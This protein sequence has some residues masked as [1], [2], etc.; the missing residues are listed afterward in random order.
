MLRM[1]VS[2]SSGSEKTSLVLS[3]LLNDCPIHK[4]KYIDWNH[5]ILVSKPLGQSE[6]STLVFAIRNNLNKEQIAQIYKDSDKIIDVKKVILNSKPYQYQD[7][8]WVDEY[9]KIN[10]NKLYVSVFNKPSELPELNTM[11]F[12]NREKP[13]ILIDDCL[14][15]NNK[16]TSEL[17]IFG[18]N[19]KLPII[20]LSQSYAR[21]QKGT[22]RDNSNMFIL[23]SQTIRNMRQMIYEEIGAQHFAS[24][25]EFVQFCKNGWNDNFGFITYNRDS[26]E[27]TQNFKKYEIIDN[28]KNE[29]M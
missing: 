5:L 18:R 12:R 28:A 25:K 4:K 13:I 8:F 10:P 19:Q 6:Y 16:R 20:I 7:S 17:S 15:E 9:L 21:V 23:F 11:Q 26:K 22:T 29:L 27:F 1:L 14:L 2:G 3:L 24:L